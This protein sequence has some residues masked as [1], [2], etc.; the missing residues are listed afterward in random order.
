[1]G[2]NENVTTER[3]QWLGSRAVGL[4]HRLV[5]PRLFLLIA[6]ALFGVV[7]WQTWLYPAAFLTLSDVWALV[8]LVAAGGCAHAALRPSRFIVA[9][10][11]AL[12]VCA[13]AGRA[14]ANLLE[15][16]I[17]PHQE[18]PARIVAS[19]MWSLIAV[20]SFIAWHAFVSP[21]AVARRVK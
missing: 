16:I 8:A 15:P 20:L 3:R 1:M 18:W 9:L 6:A 10:A 13:A 17:G 21:W 4:Y 12:V 14:A 2:Y 7:A 11:G 5:S 19:A